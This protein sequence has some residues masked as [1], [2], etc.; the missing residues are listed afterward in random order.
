MRLRIKNLGPIR[1]G[2]S[3][4]DG[5]LSFPKVTLLCGPQG[6]GKSTAA[7]LFSSMS[8]LEKWIYRNPG[9]VLTGEF[10]QDTLAWQGLD[11]YLTP[12]TE[13]VFQ[14]DLCRISFRGGR[15]DMEV[16][17]D[18]KLYLKPKVSYIPA[19]R[20]FA[21]IVRNALGVANLPKPLLDMQVEFEN[22][23]R[24]YKAGYKLPSNGY[25]F[26]YDATTGE[27]WIVN[28]EISVNGGGGSRTRLENASSGLQSMVPMMLVSDYLSNCVNPDYDVV[29]SG[30]P[31]NPGTPEQKIVIENRIHEVMKSEMPQGEKLESL[32]RY[33]SPGKR[34]INIVEEPEQNLYPETQYRIMQFLLQKVNAQNGNKLLVSTHSPFVVNSMVTASMAK[35]IFDMA[36]LVRADELR[37]ALEDLLPPD[38]AVAQSEMALYEFSDDGTISRLDADSGVFSDNNLLNQELNK[39]NGQFERMLSIRSRLSRG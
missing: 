32:T 11:D 15:S 34:F 26:S 28:G 23:K 35:S 17:G 16:I 5:F 1:S 31:Y 14:G 22:A 10:M 33:L 18:E 19:E 37:V 30:L 38:C 3:G 8:W 27:S 25:G 29:K 24:K 9:F 39:W 2:Y 7:K 4:D 12:D 36:E 6:S 20:N 21:S 13:F